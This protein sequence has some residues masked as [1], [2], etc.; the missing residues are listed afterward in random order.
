MG[1]KLVSAVLMLG[2]VLSGP[3]APLAWAQEKTEGQMAPAKKDD[4]AWEIGA[5]VVNT[6]HVPGKAILCGLGAVSGVAVLLLTFGSG[7]GA[8]ARIWDEGCSGK[9]IVTAADLKP[10]PEES[11]FLMDRPDYSKEDLQR[12][13]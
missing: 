11:D 4:R 8:T 3:L 1:F 6:W 12:T 13:K 10:Q 2:L 9:W 7:Y 5:V